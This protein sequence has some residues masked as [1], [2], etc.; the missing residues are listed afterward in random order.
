KHDDPA[1]FMVA[2]DEEP[3]LERIFEIRN[4]FAKLFRRFEV[5][6]VKDQSTAVSFFEMPNDVIRDLRPWDA[7]DQLLA[8]EFFD[9]HYGINYT[10][11]KVCVAFQRRPGPVARKILRIEV[12][13]PPRSCG[14]SDPNHRG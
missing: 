9:R 5:D 13:R 8:D 14:G 1:A 7:E 11:E 4:E 12:M 6:P 2:A 10:G 3:T